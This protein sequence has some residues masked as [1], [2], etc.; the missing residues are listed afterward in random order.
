MLPR[1]A[2]RERVEEEEDA[3]NGESL[4]K[5]RFRM[6][7][8]FYNS[9]IYYAKKTAKVDLHSK[10]NRESGKEKRICTVNN[11]ESRKEAHR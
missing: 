10:T 3:C 11:K 4:W 6:R 1:D 9:E 5:I 8:S 7:Q 2:K